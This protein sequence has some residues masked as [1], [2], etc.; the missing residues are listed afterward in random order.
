M[1]LLV[2]RDLFKCFDVEEPTT[3]TSISIPKIGTLAQSIN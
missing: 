3:E 2:V 1:N